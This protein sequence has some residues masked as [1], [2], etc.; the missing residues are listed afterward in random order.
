MSLRQCCHWPLFI[1]DWKWQQILNLQP[2]VLIMQRSLFHLY[3]A[4]LEWALLLIVTLGTTLLRCHYFFFSPH[5]LL[6]SRLHSVILTSVPLISSGCCLVSAS[7]SLQK[8]APW[9]F[10]VSSSGCPCVCVRAYVCVCMHAWPWPDKKGAEWAHLI[11][12]NQHG[13]LTAGFDLRRE[14]R[15]THTHVRSFMKRYIVRRMIVSLSYSGSVLSGDR[16]R[17]CHDPEAAVW[18]TVQERSCCGG[19]VQ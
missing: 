4:F 19:H 5:L 8:A 13:V 3:T 9:P 7:C 12:D 18:D 17:W 6:F 1:V 15:H 11:D 2:R 16:H 10:A 14:H